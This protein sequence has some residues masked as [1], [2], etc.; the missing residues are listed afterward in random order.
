M[1]LDVLYFV[2]FLGG[3]GGG[4]YSVELHGHKEC[5]YFILLI[6]S[7]KQFSKVVVSVIVV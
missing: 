1:L 2:F 3:G 6:D 4:I 7:A 5:I